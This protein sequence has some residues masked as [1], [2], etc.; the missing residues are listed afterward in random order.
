MYED[1]WY[2][3]ITNRALRELVERG[4][5][6]T[7]VRS[8]VG[9]GSIHLMWNKRNRYH[10]REATK[11]VRLVEEYSDPNIGASL[12]LQG[13]ALV[14]EGFARSE[15][16]M[17]GRDVQSYGGRKW[18]ESNH[19]LDF[20][21]ERDGKAYGI[22]V[23]NTLR[24]MEYEEFKIKIRLCESLELTP[25]FAVRMLPRNWAHELI[26]RGGF[27][28][29]LKYQLYPWSHRDLAKRVKAEL[30]LP[31]DSPRRLEDGTMDRFLKWHK[32][33]L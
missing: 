12:G 19:D 6:K 25:M 7:E 20:V 3:W 22:E 9:G 2:H 33:R 15:F 11:L 16:V 30:G 27:A 32:G 18:T 13:E 31:V 26:S 5:I 21:F 10:R 23:K 24:Y 17:R 29:I 4:R 28:L 1:R 8:L 14:L